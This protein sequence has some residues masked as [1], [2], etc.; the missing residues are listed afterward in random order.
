MSRTINVYLIYALDDKEVMLRLSNHLNTLKESYELLIWNDDPILPQQFWT[1][2]IESRLTDSDIFILLVSNVF[3][4]SSFIEQ[5]EFKL[6]VDKYKDKEATL[7]PIIIDECPWTIDFN[8]DDYNFSFKELKVFPERGKYLEEINDS[9][10]VYNNI[11][12]YVEGIVA[13]RIGGKNHKVF[14]KEKKWVSG[15]DHIKNQLELPVV[16]E[17]EAPEIEK[18]EI[19]KK[20]GVVS[21]ERA[22]IEE[23]KL[24]QDTLVEQQRE[25]EEL[26]I[27]ELAEANRL[28]E[29]KN[30]LIEEE[31]KAKRIVEE[32]N[33]I[34][35][36]AEEQEQTVMSESGASYEKEQVF[37]ESKT[38][39]N[40]KSMFLWGL[41]L[42]GLLI[43]A[44]FIFPRESSVSEESVSQPKEPVQVQAAT[45]ENE[46]IADDEEVEVPTKNKEAPFIK[47]E[48]G[49][50]HDNGI[51]FD[52][53][54]AGKNGMIAIE[55]L[56]GMILISVSV[57]MLLDGI[58]SYLSAS[59]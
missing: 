14:P 6:I 28:A 34:L 52:L 55:R 38:T 23:K 25:A 15:N 4:R 53:D 32:E 56:M 1:P 20:E 42:A 31:A 27:Q 29:E 45:T 41:G 3:I 21:E 12:V 57:Q 33:R 47:L 54:T 7:L 10:Q 30:R 22:I 48:I 35:D 58:K 59:Q 46:T 36:G 17:V 13:S 16:N 44:F 2:Q 24:V 39:I 9:S 40:K 37:E 51:I 49:E 19:E 18:R 5:M 11:M 26:R 8:S 43:A 50:L